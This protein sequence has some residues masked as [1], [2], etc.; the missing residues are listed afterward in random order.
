[1][2]HSGKRTWLDPGEQGEFYVPR[3]YWT[4]R[5]D[6]LAVVT[7]NRPQNRMTLYFFDVTT[8]GKRQVMSETSKT[9]IDVYDFYAGVQ[10]F[11]TF[12]AGGGSH[13]FFWISDRDGWQHIY[14]YDY[15]GQLLN[16]VTHGNWSVTRVEGIDPATQTIYFTSTQASPLQR[17]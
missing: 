5:A 4:S 1:N 11:M 12:P 15:S 9:W 8:G 2:V 6:T 3:I 7:L 17:Q 14:R 10:D 13:E 16:Q